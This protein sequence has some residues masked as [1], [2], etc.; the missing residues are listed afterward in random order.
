MKEMPEYAT[1][2][3]DRAKESLLAAKILLENSLF[4]DCVSR[5]YYAVLHSAKTA[6]Y[7]NGVESKTHEGVR[8]MFGLHLVKTGKIEKEFADILTEEQEDRIISDYEVDMEIGEETAKQRFNEAVRFVERIERYI[9][10]LCG[11]TR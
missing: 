11:E 10:E 6:L 5:S 3:L 8:R 2:E 4:A 7:I 9:R 1:K